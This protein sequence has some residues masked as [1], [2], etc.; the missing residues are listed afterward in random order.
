MSW[1]WLGWA[2]FCSGSRYRQSQDRKSVEG[3]ARTE[4][5]SEE[6]EIGLSILKIDGSQATPD[7]DC[8][9]E[10]VVYYDEE[11]IVGHNRI[12]EGA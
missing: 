1:V 2:F 11:E 9:P 8:K 3:P 12:V 5:Y 10:T 4:K 7:V 6:G